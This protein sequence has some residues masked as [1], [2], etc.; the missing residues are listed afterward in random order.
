MTL[1][2]T[3][4]G[5]FQ[6]KKPHSAIFRGMRFFLLSISPGLLT[7]YAWYDLAWGWLGVVGIGI[8]FLNQILYTGLPVRCFSAAITG[9]V[10]FL[11]ATPWMSWT[12]GGL[13]EASPFQN[14]LIVHGIHLFNGGIFVLAALI[15]WGLSRTV[16]GSI[17][18]TPLVW[19]CCEAVY[20]LLLP[21]KQGCL[22]L[23]FEPLIQIASIFGGAGVTL[24]LVLM[25]SVIPLLVMLAFK[26]GSREQSRQ[27]NR[28]PAMIGLAVIV[29]FTATNALWGSF[30]ISQLSIASESSATIP[31]A[32]IQGE[33]EHA[34]AH[35]S[36]MERS[37][38][39]S[40]GNTLVL[41]PECSV[42]K[43][44]QSLTDF[45]DGKNVANLSVGRGF[46]FQ[47]FP[48]PQCYLLAAGYSW[49]PQ[50][51]RGE[52][53]ANEFGFKKRPPWKLAEKFVSAFLISPEE[54]LV[55]RHDKQALMPG[56]EYTPG[57]KWCPP[58]A[59][60][61][62]SL[63]ESSDPDDSAP[64]DIQLSRGRSSAPIGEV[65]GVSIGVLLCC[66]DMAPEISRQ[67]VRQ[68]A[69]VLVTL[70]NGMSFN[71]E[72]ALKQHLAISQFRAVENN[73]YFIRCSSNGVSCMVSPT[74]KILDA[75]PCFSDCE[76]S[77]DVPTAH[78]SASW[79]SVLGNSLNIVSFLVLAVAVGY[80]AVRR[81]IT[82]GI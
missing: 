42:G 30:R 82:G 74:G 39:Y 66:E 47:P 41:W 73:R 10:G 2:S 22:L 38:K 23:E 77:V 6:S 11:M 40:G 46:K 69:D 44:S 75:L 36:L 15:S 24:Q 20:P 62:A 60:W 71:S 81:K 13:L 68:G 14:S 35:A 21:M 3:H 48:N 16:A 67:L 53:V 50:G 80:S 26:I 45:S 54:K 78:R 18:Y 7:G 52:P 79:Y 49:T 31:V 1:S 70:A 17:W 64:D 34:Q 28:R 32:I 55:G 57:E 59:R 76:L 29:A 58:L 19:M 9:Y 27:D 65:N 56:G 33:T 61:L 72:V 25:A 51:P 63:T 43:Y 37:R 4:S 5:N 12:V 8:F